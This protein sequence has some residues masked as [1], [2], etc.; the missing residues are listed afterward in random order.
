MKAKEIYKNILFGIAVGDALGVPVEFKT[1]KEIAL[2]PV[3]GMIGFGTHNQPKGTWSDDSSLTFC[4]AESLTNGYNIND[5]ANNFVKWYDQGFWTPHGN[6]FDIG[7]TTG[8]AIRNLKNGIDPILA[9][10]VDEYSNGNGSLMRILPLLP[11]IMNLEFEE[12]YR[13]ISD[14]SSLTHR[15]PR[16]ILGCLLLLQYANILLN[17]DPRLGLWS[18]TMNFKDNLNDYP[19]LQNEII[20]FQRL[21]D[22]MSHDEWDDLKIT[23][24]EAYKAT[25]FIEASLPSIAKVNVDQIKSSGYIIDTLE[26]SI[27]CLLNSSNYKDAVLLAVN[28]GGDTD[29]TAAVTGGLAGIYYGYDSIPKDW[30]NQLVRKEDIS[31]LADRLNNYYLNMNYKHKCPICGIPLKKYEA[32]PNYVCMDCYDKATDINGR[33]LEFF[34]LG[35]GGGYG[36]EYSDIKEEYLSHECYIEGKHCWADEAKFGG[37]VIQVL[38]KE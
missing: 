29:T 13:I 14:V 26:A 2:N 1:R 17:D 24:R 32:Y 23:N 18:L 21:F 4:L 27:W 11:N 6:I 8:N 31:N 22:G 9:G 37:I 7:I 12:R 35:I 19:E 33:K 34:N 5:I 30:V 16:S 20:H 10:E 15:H 3:T 25:N 38:N 28:L 36:S